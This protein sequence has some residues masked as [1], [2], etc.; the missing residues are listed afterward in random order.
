MALPVSVPLV[1]AGRAFGLTRNMTYE[2]NA[3]GRFPCTVHPLGKY[4][5]VNRADL[6]RALG[7]EDAA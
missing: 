7:I 5:R 6:F 4:Y 3:Q 1:D 2:L